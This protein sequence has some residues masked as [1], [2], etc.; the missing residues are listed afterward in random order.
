MRSPG[1]LRFLVLA[2]LGLSG[3]MLGLSR[4]AGSGSIAWRD[5]PAGTEGKAAE[6]GNDPESS[7]MDLSFYEMLGVPGSRSP[8]RGEDLKGSPSREAGEKGAY[9]V[10]AL[11]TRSRDRA[12]RL[13]VRLEAAGLRVIVTQGHVGGELIHRVRVGRYRDRAVAEIVA[14]KIRESENLDP[15]VLKEA[16]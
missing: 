12:Q 5:R 16:D 1:R 13:Q 14:K 2:V 7:E 4:W 9:V 15:W 10:Q 6:S 8:D 3:V 11:V